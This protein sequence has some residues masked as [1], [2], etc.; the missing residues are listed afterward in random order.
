VQPFS[1]RIDRTAF[2][3]GEDE[4]DEWLRTQAGQQEK[5]G[6]TRT[7]LAVDRSR[8]GEGPGH[9]FLLQAVHQLAVASRSIGFEVVVTHAISR[10]AAVFYRRAG[11]QPFMDHELHLFMPV[12]D[13][14]AT[15]DAFLD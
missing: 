5:R 1:K 3:C 4:L 8:R 12:G 7:F 15:F 11:F 2:H 10:D 13:L 6:N 9:Q 14:R